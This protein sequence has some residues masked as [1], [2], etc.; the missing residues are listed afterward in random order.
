M[1]FTPRRFLLSP[2]QKC[3]AARTF[4]AFLPD[5]R[6]S[7]PPGG[8]FLFRGFPDAA[9]QQRFAQPHRQ[10]FQKSGNSVQADSWRSAVAGK[11]GCAIYLQLD[12]VDSRRRSAVPGDD[13]P[14]GVRIVQGDREPTRPRDACC[15]GA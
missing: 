6:P 8:R 15:F 1:E 2:L 3:S 13:R 11:I 10:H 7:G 9:R 14:T 4:G 12:G 5:F